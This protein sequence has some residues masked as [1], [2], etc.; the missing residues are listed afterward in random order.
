MNN[1]ASDSVSESAEYQRRCEE[2][3]RLSDKFAFLALGQMAETIRF[4]NIIKHGGDATMARRS[5]QH[6]VESAQQLKAR[7]DELGA[8]I[9]M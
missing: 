6:C 5:L 8:E 4:E 2:H 9:G 1:R 7:L 3:R